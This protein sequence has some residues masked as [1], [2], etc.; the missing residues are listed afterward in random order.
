VIVFDFIRMLLF[1]TL[2]LVALHAEES[3]PADSPSIIL[4]RDPS[5]N[6]FRR[7]SVDK[8]GRQVYVPAPV[9]PLDDDDLPANCPFRILACRNEEGRTPRIIEITKNNQKIKLNPNKANRLT[10][11]AVIAAGPSGVFTRRL[12][13][14]QATLDPV[15]KL[16]FVINW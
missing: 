2:L 11:L 5:T 12:D 14:E 9:Q 15:D 4:S 10:I 6:R 8:H 13:D 7:I 3:L 1:S 16:P